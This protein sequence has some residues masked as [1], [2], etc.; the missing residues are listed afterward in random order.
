MILTLALVLALAPHPARAQAPAEKPAAAPIA[1]T[2][3]PAHRKGEPWWQQRLDEKNTLIAAGDVGMIF[4]GDSITQGWEGEGRELWA[5]RFAPRKALNLGFGG[6]RTQHVLWRLESH[7]L[8]KLAKP[9][10]GKAQTKLVVLMIGT[11]NSN[12]SDNTAEEI[13][14][15]IGAIVAKLRA[16]L[17]ETHVLLLSIF[18]RGEKPG[19]QREKN[20]AAS[21]LAAKHADG[22]WVHHMDIGQV[23]LESDGA[24]SKEVMPDHLH[25]SPKGYR[26]W[27]DAIEK[28]VA[29]LM[30]EKALAR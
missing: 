1:T 20:A 2:L 17:P 22:K 18:P 11:N 26:L 10:E 19:P 24:L 25:L 9:S 6:D 5:E 7:G 27:A 21:A 4:L 13:G 14:A 16:L 12:G 8:D 29:E 30:G 23:F 15:G 3:V 28:K